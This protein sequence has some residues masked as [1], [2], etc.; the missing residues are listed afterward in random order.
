MASLRRHRRRSTVLNQAR[1]AHNAR[2]NVLEVLVSGASGPASGA[3]AS[4]EAPPQTDRGAENTTPTNVS[5]VACHWLAL[6]CWDRDPMAIIALL[7]SH[8]GL[9]REDWRFLDKGARSYKQHARTEH[10]LVVCWTP[11]VDHQ[12][13]I[14]PGQVCEAA[15]LDKLRA[16][17]LALGG[18]ASRVDLALDVESA[19][20]PSPLQLWD[21][22]RQDRKA[23][24]T[25]AQ[26]AAYH[27]EDLGEGAP[28]SE[29][30]TLGDRSSETFVRVYNRR[31]PLRVEVELKGKQAAHA[32][33]EI[34]VAEEAMDKHPPGRRASV[35]MIA[36][37]RRAVDFVKPG[38]GGGNISRAA[39][40]DWWARAV[41][42]ADQAADGAPLEKRSL[43]RSLRWFR[44]QVAGT[45]R[46]LLAIVQGD[47][48]KLMPD[49]SKVPAHLAA[50]LPESEPCPA[51]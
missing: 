22:W 9:S 24:R 38:T 18:R 12:H 5:Q 49:T 30:F 45:F 31:G 20:A 4:P 6:T 2:N 46:G 8:L 27:C 21:L 37:I 34:C 29:T 44:D 32:W 50:L 33:D 3:P 16:I 28:I 13:V 35:M 19:L 15:G 11:G 17:S 23:F 1:N 10:G 7:S 39:L 25:H 41:A 14:I 47:L 40:A 43:A 48:G 51:G 26:R 42:E 36:H